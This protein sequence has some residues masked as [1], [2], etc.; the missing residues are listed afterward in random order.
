MNFRFRYRYQSMECANSKGTSAG[1]LALE[2]KW[3]NANSNAESVGRPTGGEPK[4]N[5]LLVSSSRLVVFM[6][7]KKKRRGEQSKTGS[8]FV[9]VI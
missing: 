2:D 7:G 6:N 1:G 3:M 5:S 8:N 4:K 9:V